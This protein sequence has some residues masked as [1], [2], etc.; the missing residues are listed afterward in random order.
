MARARWRRLL[1]D[2]RARIVREALAA[3][4]PLHREVLILAEYE[5]L[6][7]R[8]DRRDRGRGGGRGEG[9]AAPGAQEAAGGAR[10]SHGERRPGASSEDA[11]KADRGQATGGGPER[12]DLRAFLRQWQVPAPPRGDRG[13]PA[14]D[15]PAAASEAPARLLALPRRG[16]SLT[17]LLAYQVRGDPERPEAPPSWPS[18]RGQ[19]A[20]SG[21]GAWSRP[22]R[23]RE[24]SVIRRGPQACPRRPPCLRSRAMSSSSRGRRSSSRNS[25]GPLRACGRRCPERRCRGRGGARGRTGA[26]IR[27]AQARDTVL[28]VPAGTGR[29][30]ETDWPFVYRSLPTGG[31]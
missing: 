7:S 24:A 28:P 1:E 16:G 22:P 15:V 11:M 18:G 14:S 12:E 30:S 26:A 8:D 9:A 13:G 10:G 27:A 29:R 4:A 31:R 19:A 3:L 25:P 6:D 20:T 2:E 17:L 5:E 23:R 21:T